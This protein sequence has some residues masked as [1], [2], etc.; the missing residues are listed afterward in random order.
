MSSD[1]INVIGDIVEYCGDVVA[2]LSP[3]A[4]PTVLADFVEWLSEAT[5]D[6][7]EVR[8]EPDEVIIEAI[9]ELTKRARAGFVTLQDVKDVLGQIEFTKDA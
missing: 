5:V 2:R 6:K 7:D 8:K 4:I 3:Q 1:Q 9:A